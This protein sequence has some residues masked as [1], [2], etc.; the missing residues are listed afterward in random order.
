MPKGRNFE[1]YDP[2]TGEWTVSGETPVQLWD[3]WLSCGRLSQEP[4]AGPTFE[5]GPGVLRPDGTVFYTGSNTC[6]N[7]SGATAIYDYKVNRWKAGPNFPGTN[8]ISDGPASLEVNGNVLMMASPAYGAPPSTFFEW[9]GKS[10][11]AVPGTPNSPTDGSFVGNMLLLPTGQILLTDFSDD[12]ELYNSTGGPKPQW[13]P[14]VVAV[15]ETLKAG[16]T[17]KVI[18]YQFNGLSRVRS[19][20]TMCRPLPTSLSSVLSTSQ[21]DT[22]DTAAPTIPAQWRSP[23]INSTLFTSTSPG[24]RNSGPACLKS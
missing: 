11:T 1:L 6:P 15:S 22:Y 5:L 2:T 19:T 9:N 4:N 14:K 12:I 17:Y 18:G 8:N 13:A 3:S 7:E 10:L 23:P 20:A 16:G 21:P 24:I